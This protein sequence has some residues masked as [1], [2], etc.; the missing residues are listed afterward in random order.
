MASGIDIIARG[1]AGAKADLVDGKVPASQLPSYVDDVIEGYYFD[2]KFYKDSAHT[3]E[4][5]GESGKIYVDITT[6]SGSTYRWS[7][8]T[9][10]EISGG[11]SGGCEVIIRSW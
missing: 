3:V 8:S 11:G 7:G 6:D 5:N 1:M 9:Y 10:I 2:G 4:I